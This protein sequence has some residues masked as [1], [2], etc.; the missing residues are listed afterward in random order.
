MTSASALEGLIPPRGE[1]SAQLGPLPLEFTALR[2]LLDCSADSVSVIDRDGIALFITPRGL[3]RFGVTD[4]SLVIGRPWLDQWPDGCAAV[5][6][7]ALDEA[8]SGQRI[9]RDIRCE[10]DRGEASWWEVSFTPWNEGAIGDRIEFV[11]AV[12]RDVTDRHAAIEN[13]ELLAR[14][15]HHR[16]GNMLS[17]VQAI[18]RISAKV[19]RD[20]N[21]F[22]DS[23]EERVEALA[24]AHALLT[25]GRQGEVDLRSLLRAELAPF[26]ETG[27]VILDGPLIIVCEPAVSAICLAVHELTSNAVKY[28]ALSRSGG[29][30]RVSWKAG[31]GGG[32]CL[33]WSESMNQA[34]CIG[35]PGFGSMLLDSLL[36]DQLLIK[37]EWRSDGL[38]ATIALPPEIM[39][40]N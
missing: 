11:I 26:H 17:M 34:L 13:A 1:S 3:N 5:L 37:R 6:S 29:K 27:R 16:V 8:V 14:E 7:D 25:I 4:T 40:A 20:P 36:L 24:R 38:S 23:V 33:R 2:S 30:L 12:A 21:H 15:L 28:G 39:S 19:H 32:I 31:A 18:V 9:N 22:I 35:P 10:N